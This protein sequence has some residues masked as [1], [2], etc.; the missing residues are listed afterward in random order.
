MPGVSWALDT[1]DDATEPNYVSA[2]LNLIYFPITSK[3]MV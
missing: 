1:F 2:V 3:S